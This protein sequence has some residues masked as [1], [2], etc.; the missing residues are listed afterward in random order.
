MKF[1]HVLYGA[2]LFLIVLSLA[3]TACARVVHDEEYGFQITIPNHWQSNAFMDGTDKIWAFA[4]PDNNAAVRIRSFKAPPGLS[5]TTL[6][7]AFENHIL[8]GGQRLVLEPYTLNGMV[9]QMAGYKGRFNNI[10]VGIGCFYTI[11]KQNA[12]IV[13]SMIPASL[14]KD[15]SRETDAILNTFT[16]SGVEAPRQTA[17][18]VPRPTVK[19]KD[20]TSGF[21]RK[22]GEIYT[23]GTGDRRTK[24]RGGTYLTIAKSDL[25]STASVKIETLSGSLSYVAVHARYEGGIWKTAYQ[26][27][28]TSFSVGRYFQSF[29]S[30]ANCTHLIV[31]VNGAH[32][33][34]EPAACRAAV[35]ICHAG[36]DRVSSKPSESGMPKVLPG[37]T[38]SADYQVLT[39]DDSGF[40]FLYPKH[41]QR[42][43]QSEG[44][45]QWADPNAPSG[46][47]VIMVLQTL[48][49]SMGNSLQSVHGKLVNQ[50]KNTS[51]AKLLSSQPLTVN[52]LSAYDL[53]F[54][55]DQ[56]NQRKHFYYLVLDLKGPN[57]AAVS[58][59]G[60]ESLQEEMGRHFSKLKESVR[61]TRMSGSGK[62]EN[63]FPTAQSNK[64]MRD[65][66][67]STPMKAPPARS[68]HHVP[69][70]EF[71]L[72][73]PYAWNDIPDK[74]IARPEASAF[75]MPAYDAETEQKISGGR[76]QKNYK[77]NGRIVASKTFEGTLYK[78]LSIWKPDG[79]GRMYVEFWRD[80]SVSTIDY[81]EGM[82]KQGI[83]RFWDTDG[84]IAQIATYRDNKPDGVYVS[85][86]R[87]KDHF[88]R[89]VE[90]FQNGKRH[91]LFR[92][93]FQQNGRIEEESQWQ[94]GVEMKKTLYFL[95]GKLRGEL[96]YQNGKQ[97][98]QFYL[99]DGTVSQRFE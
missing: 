59:V 74:L 39:I 46:S 25:P 10:D 79:R 78:S 77:K 37:G 33:K 97:I 67:S 70:S 2:V 82:Y 69:L 56:Q 83:C 5:M 21:C 12:Y 9:G 19:E 96:K 45:S 28:L 47:R 35:H 14:F 65:E 68:T 11:Q 53:R 20:E 30:Q 61:Q 18:A 92:T 26:G 7:S 73:V 60:P 23:D 93:Y 24:K 63:A 49:R 38:G 42:F 48:S 52:G 29:L 3:G 34:Y 58:F 91:G 71:P 8:A 84:T 44:Q 87:T 4:A 1:R 99:E 41:F 15:R 27:P 95:S 31:S 6:I 76:I 51:A 54:T 17:P 40:E 16:I 32:E 13:W 22:V 55:L 81:I 36:D 50:V 62:T 85:W 66:S 86:Y 75:S 98:G 90:H 89:R 43:Q 94:D 72:L 88:L 64:A 80:G 57:V